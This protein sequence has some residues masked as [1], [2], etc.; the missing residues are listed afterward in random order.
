VWWRDKVFLENILRQR[1][2]GWLPKGVVNYD[3]LLISSANDA[4]EELARELK[5]NDVEQWKW[6]RLHPL[7]M[8]HPL[9][10]S[11]TLHSLFSIGP[12]PQGGTID[13][14]RA[15]GAGHGPAMRVVSDLSNFDNSLMEVSTGESGQVASPYFRD[16]FT[17]WFAGRGIPA[18]F[19]EAAEDRMRAHRLT[20]MPAGGSAPP[21]E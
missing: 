12:Y 10:R 14:V 5:T 9:G 3:V 7:N 1:P 8:L 18:P 19:S 15:M 6:G 20:L 16:Q 13:T 11:G 21:A 4:A 2:P 17:E